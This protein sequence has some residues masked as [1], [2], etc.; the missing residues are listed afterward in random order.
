M[1]FRAEKGHSR[2]SAHKEGGLGVADLSDQQG[3]GEGP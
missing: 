1:G 2:A 3:A